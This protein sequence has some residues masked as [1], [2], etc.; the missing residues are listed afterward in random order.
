MEV[1]QTDQLLRLLLFFGTVSSLLAMGH[2]GRLWRPPNRAEMNSKVEHFEICPDV[3]DKKSN[4]T[5][6]HV[7][8][9]QTVTVMLGNKVHV[10]A[11]GC[12]PHNITWEADNGTLHT[13]LLVDPDWPIKK[14]RTINEFPHWMVGNIPGSNVE[15]GE[16]IIDYVGY[17]A[18][19]I[20]EN[21]HRYTFLV[22]AQPSH[23]P[24][25]FDEPRLN[26]T[27]I[28]ERER[29]ANFSG[30]NIAKKYNLKNVAINFFLVSHKKKYV[31]DDYLIDIEYWDD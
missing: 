22:Y 30:K 7:Q 28:Y 8:F 20:D 6:I 9:R 26:N 21:P 15:K 23:E 11:L 19:I 1:P 4:L 24:I 12:K 3:I 2:Y 14:P 16:T 27:Q 13:L 18:T 25:K 5:F 31:N 29:F 10:K 17:R